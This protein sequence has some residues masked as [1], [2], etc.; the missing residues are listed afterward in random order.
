MAARI[1]GISLGVRRIGMA[2]LDGPRLYEYQMNVFN[3]VWSKRKLAAIVSAIERFVS[4]YNP[5]QVAVKLP[6]ISSKAPAV[7]QLI[8]SIQ[9]LFTS[10]GV[11]LYTYTLNDLKRG[12]QVGDEAN[13]AQFMRSVLIAYPELLKEYEREMKNKIRYQEKLFEAVASAHLLLAVVPL[14]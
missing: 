13:K 1:L 5:L 6:A 8:T 9:K 4:R 12:W 10:L 3:E 7:R 14:S 11:T 2:V